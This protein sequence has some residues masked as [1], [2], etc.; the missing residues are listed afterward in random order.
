MNK[1]ELTEIYGGGSFS[2][3]ALNAI[4]KAITSIYEIGRR[5]GSALTRYKNGNLC[6]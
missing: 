3:S 6:K 1:Q 5:I 4:I 2:S